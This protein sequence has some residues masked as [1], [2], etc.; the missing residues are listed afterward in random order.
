MCCAVLLVSCGVWGRSVLR[1]LISLL[2][3]LFCWFR[4]ASGVSDDEGVLHGVLFGSWHGMAWNRGTST[5][6]LFVCSVRVPVLE[7]NASH[8]APR[9]FVRVTHHAELLLCHPSYS[10][11]ETAHQSGIRIFGR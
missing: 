6:R 1:C 7:Y 4:R 3:V 9:S 10:E 8:A 2:R 11:D 5:Y